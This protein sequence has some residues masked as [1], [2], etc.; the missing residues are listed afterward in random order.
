MQKV[1]D[2]S[3]IQGVWAQ[4]NPV[5]LGRNVAEKTGGLVASSGAKK[6]LLVY[7]AGLKAVG[8]GEKIK[9]N[10]EMAVSL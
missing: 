4:R 5:M 8:T 1:S 7:D 3:M 6:V 2:Y 10:L 9:K